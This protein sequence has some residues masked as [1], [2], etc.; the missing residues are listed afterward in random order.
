MLISLV[1]INV[2]DF[3]LW[4]PYTACSVLNITQ[5]QGFR[6]KTLRFLKKWISL[7][8]M[9][10]LSILDLSAQ[11]SKIRQCKIYKHLLSH[12]MQKKIRS[13]GEKHIRICSVVSLEIKKHSS[14]Y[15]CPKETVSTLKS[16]SSPNHQPNTCTI[17][18]HI[19]PRVYQQMTQKI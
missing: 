5:I 7:T 3:K 6:E 4:K 12:K 15:P 13:N 10:L 19:S 18:C 11:V 17:L 1:Q 2:I 8:N 9:T 16:L 14:S